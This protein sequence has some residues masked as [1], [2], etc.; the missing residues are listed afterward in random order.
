MK[1]LIAVIIF[2]TLTILLN[3]SNPTEIEH[4]KYIKNLIFNE[5][6]FTIVNEWELIGRSLGSLVATQVIDSRVNVQ[7]FIL[8]SLVKIDNKTIGIGVAGQIF[9]FKK[10]KDII[11]S[12][13]V[14]VP[15]D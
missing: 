5:L 8:F 4:E 10:I 3:L 7:N 9:H 6:D 14:E 11:N 15:I 12:E 13:S 2:C 1:K